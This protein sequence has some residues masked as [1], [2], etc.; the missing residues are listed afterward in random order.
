MPA[1]KIAKV[2]INGRLIGFHEQV[3]KLTEELIA[4]RRENKISPL[5]NI[6]Y[7]DDTNE[8]YIN[9]DAGRVQRPLIVVD[10]GKPRL[11]DDD[12]RKLAEGKLTWQE[13]VQ[14]G[15]I[16]YLDSE[17]EENAFV[18]MNEGELTKEHTH[19][20]INPVVSLSIITSM[21]PYLQHDMAGKALHGAKM[22]KQGIGISG[23]NYNLRSDTEG[24][25]LYYPQKDIVRTKT[26]TFLDLDKRPQVQNFV[27]AIMPYRGFNMLDAL[28]MNK[29]SVERGVGRNAYYRA[30]EAVE[31]RYPGGQTDRFEVPTEETVGYLGAPVYTKLGEDGLV[32]LEQQVN[33]RDIVIG[34]T[35]PPRFLEEIS[36]FGVVKEK[37]RE[38]SIIT[39]KGKP[40]SVDRVIVTENED[41]NKLVKVKVRST[42]IPEVGDKFSSRHGQKG[43]L[44][45]IVEEA[46]MPFTASGMKP[47]LILN[48]HSI[49][50]RMTVGHLLE[51][52]AGKVGS[53]KAEAMDGTPFN[54]VPREDLERALR[55]HG[56][57]HDGKEVF[58]DGVTGE[59]IEGE[60]FT[61]V[62]SYRRLFHMVAH[63][64]QARARGPVQILTR[65]PTEG[66]EKEGGLRFGEMEGET[67]VGHGAAMLLQEKFIE[68]SD[69]VVELVC[70][71]CG[72]I[73]INDQI[74]NRRY[75]P[76]CDGSKVYPVEM[77]YGFKLLI[78]ELKAL[79]IMCKMV[80]GDKV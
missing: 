76:I 58:Y 50:S 71:K 39:R 62:V 36:E 10:N 44:G 8:L 33:E 78:D 57:R 40:G 7:H 67:L 49:P 54:S 55:E 22:F 59:R 29:G 9:T 61:G 37:R 41:G 69:K 2:Y 47:D 26:M 72:V 75:C 60:I 11:T 42:M 28:V 17:E 18:A 16:E 53:I 65:Q 20:E 64:V 1:K 31:T 45:A 51:M 27:V 5:V 43:V 48:P 25:L 34:R 70:E 13:T 79:G 63:K 4:A 56:F 12:L 15:K 3:D 46:D 35:S 30:Y 21:I 52:L 6:A 66:K 23:I 14:Q 68:D 77:S 19:L 80:I 32:N 73:A 74:R 38:S 24:Y